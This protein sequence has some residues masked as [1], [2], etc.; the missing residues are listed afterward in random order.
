MGAVLESVGFVSPLGVTLVALALTV[1]AA[2]AHAQ[3]VVRNNHE[4]AYRGPIDLRVTLPDGHYAGNGASA[5]VRGG[6]AHVVATLSPRGNVTL[7]RRGV[8]LEYPFGRGPLHVAPSAASLALHWQTRSLGDIALALAVIPGTSATIDDAVRAF[9]PVS[10]VW[11]KAAGGAL[12]GV[13]E[14]DGFAV[15][16]VARPYGGGWLDLRSTVVRRA[17]V[18]GPAYVALVRRVVTPNTSDARIRFNGRE[19]AG[20]RSPSTWDRDFWYVKGV[21]WMRWR[22]G[23]VSVLSVNGFTPVP[24]VKHDSTWA[25]ASHFYVWE[26]TRQTGDTTYLVAEIAGPNPDQPKG[27]GYMA[28]VPYASLVPGDTVALKWRLAIDAAPSRDWAESQLRVFAGTRDVRR[29]GRMARAELGVPHTSFGMSYFPYSTFTENFDY[30]RVPT[31][32]SESFW[33]IAPAMWKQWRLWTPRMRSDMHIIRA[34]GF[35]F[36]RLHHLELLQS[37]DV[38]ER[39][40]FMDFYAGEAKALGLKL[41]IDTEGPAQWVT[42]IVG[43]YRDQVIGV[44]LENEVLIPGITPDDPARWSALY[45]AA[46]RAAPEADVFLTSAGNNSMFERLRMLGVP[47]DRVGLHAYKHGPQW[48]EA[49]SSHVLGTAGYATELGKPMTLGEFNWKDLTRLSPEARRAEFDTIFTQVMTPRAVHQLVEFQFQEQMAFNPSVAGTQSRHYEAVGVDRRPKPEAFVTM[50]KIRQYG[51][52]DAPVRLLPVQVGEVRF[53]HGRATARFSVTNHTRRAV[54]IA[55]DALAFDGATSRLTSP[56][57]MR[58]APGATDSGSVAL[59]LAPD[60]RPGAYH[61]F[62][63]ARYDNGRSIGWGV[64]S[65]EGVPQLADTS[66]LGNRVTYAQGLGVVG[67]VDW[68]RPLAVV[69]G[70]K[71]AVL[72]VEQAYQLGNTLQ[73]ATGKAVRICAERDLPDSLA[74]RGTVLL[75]VGTAATN[76]LI[77]STNTAVEAG[78]G[79]IA[80]YTTGGKQWLVL[81]GADAKGVQAAVVELELRYWPNA[82]DAALR[83][84]GME[85][86]AA[87]GNRISG[88]HIDPP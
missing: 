43:R 56:A 64:A 11:T 59:T 61:H 36:V 8:P 48:K 24:S 75:L 40:A 74:R 2:H 69:F 45:A 30:Y 25:E 18:T 52:P 46:K 67:T 41:F 39:R 27:K 86:G 7:T 23:G 31:L 83:L 87:L 81:T 20:A 5:E 3:L 12:H 55:V 57:S 19:L 42:E 13:A 62:I 17:A 38:A 54:N 50:E 63:S 66:V 29:D 70:D 65:N 15:D 1:G 16:V 9:T 73:S 71:T 47:F 80:H 85:R 72:E 53:S 21:D 78:R 58:L 28:V 60:A 76:A 22:S 82:K 77:A 34:M 26:R 84:V 35:D 88:V 44:E 79:T 6:R 33:P 49:W 68:S 32:S 14:Q 4:I 51:R 37:L 10:L